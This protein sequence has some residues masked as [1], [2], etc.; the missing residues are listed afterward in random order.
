MIKIFYT[1]EVTP[2]GRL[3]EPPIWGAVGV[4]GREE[5]IMEPGGGGWGW[6]WAVSEGGREGGG[7]DG[8]EGEAREDYRSN[9]L[10]S[11]HLLKF[12]ANIRGWEKTGVT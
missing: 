8:G 1:C 2:R 6:S 10:L 4:E 12:H 7:D 5:E 3:K 11:L 9:Q